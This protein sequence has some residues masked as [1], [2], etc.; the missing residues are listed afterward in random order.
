MTD[1]RTNLAEAI[2]RLVH[3]LGLLRA[4]ITGPSTAGSS[5]SSRLFA[6][7]PPIIDDRAGPWVGDEPLGLR[8]YVESLETQLSLL[9]AVCLY[10][11]EGLWYRGEEVLS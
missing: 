1:Y 8:K 11:P 7:H 10:R 6:Y 5:S 9:R 3:L 2:S 4:L